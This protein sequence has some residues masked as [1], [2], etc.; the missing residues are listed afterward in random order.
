MSYGSRS[1]QASGIRVPAGDRFPLSD[2]PPGRYT[3][4]SGRRA[5]TAWRQL[6]IINLRTDL[7]VRCPNTWFVMA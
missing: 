2:S 3:F 1:S 6:L 5:H 7:A 4:S